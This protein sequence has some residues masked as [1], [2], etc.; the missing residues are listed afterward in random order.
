MFKRCPD[1]L[2]R[3]S[4]AALDRFA[5]CRE[6][7]QKGIRATTR[8]LA[9]QMGTSQRMIEKHYGHDEIEDYRDELS[10]LNAART[11]GSHAARTVMP[12]TTI[13]ACNSPLVNRRL[14]YSEK[15]I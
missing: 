12:R 6:F 1:Y 3:S 4:D 14:S 7:V 10:G 9:K 13:Y 2:G 8:A 5:G 15:M 11:M